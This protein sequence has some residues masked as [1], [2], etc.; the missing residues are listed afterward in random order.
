MGAVIISGGFD[1]IHIGHLQM[2]EEASKISTPL[3]VILNND[4]F[5]IKKKNFIFMNQEERK[6]IL[7]SIKGVDKVFISVDKDLTVRKS[8][9]EL[10]KIQEISFFANGG[11]RKTEFDIPE[12]QICKKMDIKLVFDIGGSKIQSSSSLIDNFNSF[13]KP[14][15]HYKTHLKGDKFLL[16]T[17]HI[18]KHEEISLQTHSHREEFWFITSGNAEIT[19]GEK[20]SSKKSKELIFVPPKVKHRIKNISSETLVITEIQYGEI[21]DEKDIIRLEDKYNRKS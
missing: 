9:E 5:L 12:S 4:D 2:I 11:D 6:K 3:I 1:P 10:S 19:I 20:V 17:L 21:L 7:E 15:G 13:K 14:W 8:I 18:N 16:K